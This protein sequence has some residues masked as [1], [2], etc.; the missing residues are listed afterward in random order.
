MT[1]LNAGA[2]DAVT[3]RYWSPR[4]L[5]KL[6]LERLGAGWV[7]ND[8]VELL[9]WRI[10]SG[11]VPFEAGITTDG[12]DISHQFPVIPASSAYETHSCKPQT[13]PLNVTTVD[14]CF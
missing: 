3:V 4:P 11:S 14:G 7:S 9:S 13:F 2:E 5:T 8:Q 6:R 10:N 1:L 12:L